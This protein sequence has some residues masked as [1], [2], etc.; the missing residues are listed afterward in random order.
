MEKLPSNDLL[1]FLR[2][3]TTMNKLCNLFHPSNIAKTLQC[4]FRSRPE[5]RRHVIWLLV[6]CFGAIDLLRSSERKVD[7]LY[8]RYALFFVIDFASFGH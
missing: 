6:L 8:L 3:L 2:R 5:S 4:A 7:S 1:P